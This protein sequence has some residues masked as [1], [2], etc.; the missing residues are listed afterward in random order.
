VLQ[1]RFF[2]RA[3]IRYHVRLAASHTSDLQLRRK[4]W[5]DFRVA[6][7]QDSAESLVPVEFVG[8]K[9]LLII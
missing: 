4:K 8:K 1:I 2:Y 9:R 3:P 5:N 6:D 7:L